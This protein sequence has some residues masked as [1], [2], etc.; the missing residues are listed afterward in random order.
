MLGILKQNWSR[1]LIEAWALGMFMISA[2]LFAGLLE[3]PGLPVRMLIDNPILRR[4]LMGIAMGLTL[5]GL[6][7]SRWG[8]RS[9]AHM[10]PALTLTFLY[11]KKI[12]RRDAFFYILAQF[13]GGAAGILL[14]KA[15]FFNFVNDPSV[16]YVQTLPGPEGVAIA[17]VCELLISF[18][19]LL[20]VLYSSNYEK[21][22]PYTGVFA[23]GLLMLYITFE[24]P[25]SGTSM[26][27]ARTVASAIAAGHF[28]FLWIYFT[29]P[30]LGMLAAAKVWTLWICRK[31]DFRCS[32]HQV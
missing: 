21:T 8:K 18:C 15:L 26:N 20:T 25:L 1:Y 10:N 29:A 30:V 11:L 5:T 9:G 2:A 7:Y 4:W 12:E 14:F 19:L 16:N 23:A 6:V 27:P 32:F 17:F 13:I 24:S 28:S 31:A 22:A 3:M